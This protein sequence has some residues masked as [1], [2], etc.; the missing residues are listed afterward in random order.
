MHLGLGAPRYNTLQPFEETRQKLHKPSFFHFS[1]DL[2]FYYFTFHLPNFLIT[3]INYMIRSS[4]SQLCNKNSV[5]LQ[6]GRL[7]HNH[8]KI[9]VENTW[10]IILQNNS[11]CLLLNDKQMAHK[12]LFSLLM[13]HLSW[14][15]LSKRCS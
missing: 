13:K 7:D 12:I 1:S 4:H 14:G 2:M 8:R 6:G 3:L 5:K 15:V 9:P 11:K 10:I